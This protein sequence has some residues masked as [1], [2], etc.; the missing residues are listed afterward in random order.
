MTQSIYRYGT[1]LLFRKISALCNCLSDE[2]LDFGL[3]HGDNFKLLGGVSAKEFCRGRSKQPIFNFLQSY[4][5]FHVSRRGE[6]AFRPLHVWVSSH[7]LDFG[8]STV[9]QCTGLHMTL[10]MAPEAAN[11]P[12]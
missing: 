3:F 12:K 11:C 7:F 10:S 6:T 8:H 9:V 2:C 4:Y 5:H 1:C